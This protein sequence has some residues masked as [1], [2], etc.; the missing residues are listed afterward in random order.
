MR[1]PNGE[2]TDFDDLPGSPA[3]FS[4]INAD[5]IDA[6]AGGAGAK[7]IQLGQLRLRLLPQKELTAG[8]LGLPLGKLVALRSDGA[9]QLDEAHIPPINCIGASHTLKQWLSQLHG[10]A[11]Q[12]RDTL[13]ARLSGQA[14]STQAGEVSDFLILQILN[15]YEPLLGHMIA[16]PETNPEHA[17]TLLRTL[18]GELSTFVRNTTRKAQAHPAYIH[19]SPLTS[20]K[21]LVD[22]TRELLNNVLA[23]SAQ[24]IALTPSAHGQYSA[25]LD[26]NELKAYAGLIVA[27][28]AHL[29]AERIA[30]QFTTHAKAAPNDRLADLV[31]SHLPGIALSVLP[32]A[33]RQL[34]FNAGYV[35]FQLEPRGV[36]WE[37][38]LT[39]GGLGL[40]LA[41]D[42]PG[43]HIELW[44]VK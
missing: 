31:R 4:V 39:H 37:H 34:P 13:A 3:R 30:T 22:D 9:A 40:H 43:L 36:L 17:Y 29:S 21:A 15:R 41:T 18:A 27:V 24:N 2:E 23:R 20:F 44:G 33:P 35:Y 28:T 38:L 19:L 12:R 10:N 7:E 8:W 14:G 32:V 42:L 11:L 1:T 6:N 25:S 26:P 5:V 16:V